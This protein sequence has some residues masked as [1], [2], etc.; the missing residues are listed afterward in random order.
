MSENIHSKNIHIALDIGGTKFMAAAINDQRKIVS[1]EKV[2]T[3]KSLEE[4]LTLLKNLTY[5]V[6]K[7]SKII[8]IGA[9]AGGPLNHATGIVSPLHFPEWRNVPLKAI[10]EEEFKVPFNVDVD[11]NAAALAEYK[12]SNNPVDRLLYVT[13]STGLG[14]GFIIDGEIYRGTNGSHPEVGHQVVKST[15]HP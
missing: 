7:N 1:R 5:Q 3:P 13:L 2:D 14:G 6:S 12:F 8:S 11:T 10:M 9:S 4:G 15:L